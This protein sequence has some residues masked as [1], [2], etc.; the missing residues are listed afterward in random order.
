MR[1]LSPRALALATLAALGLPALAGAQQH[2]DRRRPATPDA[3][4]RIFGSFAS[5][6]IVGWARDSVAVVGTVPAGARFEGNFAGPGAAAVPMVKM[7]LDD[8]SDS[9]AGRARLTL[10]VPARAR[11]W[12]KAGSA[13]LVASDVTGGLDLNVIGGSVTVSGSPREVNVEAMDANVVVRGTPE[14]LRVKTATGAI[15]LEGGSPDVALT[16]VSGPIA[17]RGGRVER[18]KLESVT[19]TVGFAGELA[20]GAVLDVDTHAGAIDVRLPRTGNVDV[21]AVTI[22]G[23]IE[24]TL[25]G[26]PAVPGREGRGQEI[27]LA[28]GDGGSRVVLRSFKGIIHLRPR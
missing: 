22:T 4:V 13:E 8:P 15:T 19:G 10:Y 14:W 25:T 5:L 9:A 11:V 24:N 20:R 16:S 2:V 18:A 1:Q 12:A 17:V 6:R 3:S 27:G 7:Y 26:R 28:I 21:D 23:T